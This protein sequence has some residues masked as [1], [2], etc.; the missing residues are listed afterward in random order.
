M[1]SQFITVPVATLSAAHIRWQ[2]TDLESLSQL[3]SRDFIFLRNQG[4]LWVA[5]SGGLAARRKINRN[6]G[7]LNSEAVYGIGNR[8]PPR[9]LGGEKR[10][11]EA[12]QI[13]PKGMETFELRIRFG[14]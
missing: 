14:R 10:I 12:W 7:I 9:Y 5:N 11:S 4:K 8:L 13:R 6:P 3:V 2:E 1:S